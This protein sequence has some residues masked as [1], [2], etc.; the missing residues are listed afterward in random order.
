MGAAAIGVV[1][2]AVLLASAVAG[3]GG[4]SHVGT[5]GGSTSGGPDGRASTT[6]ATT[7]R[8]T[9]TTVVTTEPRPTGPEITMAFAGDVNG[10]PLPDASMA[11]AM[12]A[13]LAPMHEALAAADISIANLES[14]ITEQGTATA[15]KQ[16]TFRLPATALDGFKA[17][18]IDVAG[19]ANNHT[20]DFGVAG[21]EDA[22]EAKAKSPIPLIGIGH[23]ED[24]AYAPAR[25]TVRG[26][27]VAIIAASQVLPDS[28]IPLWTATPTKPG[29]A[30]AKRV[31]RLAA[32]VRRARRS[33]DVVVVFLHW[34]VEDT[35]CPSKDQEKLAGQLVAAG[36]DAVVGAHAHRVLAGGY[37][38]RG[39][40]HYGLGNFGFFTDVPD[41][42]KTGVLTLTFRGRQVVDGSWRPGVIRNRSPHPLVGA[43]AL[44]AVDEW[45]HQRSCTNLTERPT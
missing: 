35:T 29:I 34:G 28:L 3:T 25:F 21:L 36:A 2:A 24:E 6:L 45:Q 11:S 13:R 9:T 30:S 10:E 14:S 1:G 5:G 42:A 12:A 37:L 4:S 44:R 33:A 31:D 27:R 22:L 8:P 20:M 16:Y 18:G 15:G 39:Y 26:Q 43:A 23:D 7:P 17:V 40:I 41:S 32:E 38:G 19:N